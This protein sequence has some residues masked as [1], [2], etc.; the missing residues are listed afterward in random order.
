[1]ILCANKVDLVH[2][3]KVSE[4]Q[5]RDLAQRLRVSNFLSGFVFFS[6]FV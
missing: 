4:E 1:M 6:S 5:V 3:R 2:Q